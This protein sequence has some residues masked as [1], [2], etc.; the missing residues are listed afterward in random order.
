MSRLGWIFVALAGLMG[1]V[2]GV[3]YQQNDRYRTELTR[4]RERESLAWLPTVG[5]KR[6][7]LRGTSA[8]GADVSLQFG[9]K[10]PRRLVLIF[11]VTCPNCEENW[12]NWE[13]LLGR[14]SK[15]GTTVMPVTVWVSGDIPPDYSRKH[16]LDR[17]PLI[18]ANPETIEDYRLNFVPETLL[19]DRDGTVLFASNGLLTEGQVDSILRLSKS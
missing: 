1:L 7:P 6:K 10:E 12:P 13:R 9:E 15:D 17:F 18:R 14:L 8:L 4:L 5:A 11:S 3:L 2:N 16:G 19:L